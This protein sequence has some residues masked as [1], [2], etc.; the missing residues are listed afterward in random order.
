[1]N[2]VILLLLRN[3][4]VI[5]RTLCPHSRN[6]IITLQVFHLIPIGKETFITQKLP[7]I[8]IYKIAPPPHG[9]TQTSDL[10]IWKTKV[11]K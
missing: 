9:K 8:T 5:S 2:V 1:M 11:Y 6:D 7:M 10:Q 4:S 3:A